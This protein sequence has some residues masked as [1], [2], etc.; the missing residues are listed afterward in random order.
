MSKK[1]HGPSCRACKESEARCAWLG[2][3]CSGC[4]HWAWWSPDGDYIGPDAGLDEVTLRRKERERERQ[5]ARYHAK[6][7]AS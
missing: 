2:G 4:S 1:E 5:R 6:K 3:C 7:S